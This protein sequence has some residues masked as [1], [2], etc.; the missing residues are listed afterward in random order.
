MGERLAG[1][2]VLV[3]GGA[4][5]QGQAMAA[6]AASE[7]AD[8]AICDVCRDI[9]ALAYP[10]ATE[11]DLERTAAQIRSAGRRCH[12]SVVDVRDAE[13]LNRFVEETVQ[14]LGRLDVVCANAGIVSYAPLLDISDAEWDAVL[15]VNLRGVWNT[16]RPSARQMLKQ[17]EGS[18]ILTSS[19]AGREPGPETTHYAASKHGVLGLMRQAA[20]ELAPGGVRVNAIMPGPVWSPMLDNDAVREYIVKKPGATT[21]E[22]LAAMRQ[23]VALKGRGAMPPTVIADA[24][25][26]LASDE[27]RNVTGV[28]IPVDA[29]HMLLPGMDGSDGSP[30]VFSA[31]D[32]ESTALGPL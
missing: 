2:V 4:R 12:S 22:A 14:E 8:V 28:A 1:R 16:I 31:T 24:M 20:Y 26:W 27:A 13:A 9:D 21:E 25:I 3:T 15:G 19:I 18:M 6:K 17:G 11:D 10:L 30:S 7:G 32:Y 29:G 23:W 5:G